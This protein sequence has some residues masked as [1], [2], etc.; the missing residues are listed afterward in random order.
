MSLEVQKSSPL[1][2][3]PRRVGVALPL[4]PGASGAGRIAGHLTQRGVQ[5]GG[6]SQLRRGGVRPGAATSSPAPYPQAKNREQQDGPDWQAKAQ[7]AW[8][9][10]YSAQGAGPAG[11]PGSVM[12]ASA[13]AAREASPPPVS[14]MSVEGSLCRKMP[15]AASPNA[16]RQ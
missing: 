3:G 5:V 14:W 15:S 13:P 16:A 7:K 1:A 9:D 4:H 8:H 12:E 10:Y 11:V 2:C 6:R